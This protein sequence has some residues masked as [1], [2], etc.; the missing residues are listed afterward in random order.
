MESLS[1]LQMFAAL[2][3]RTCPRT[4]EDYFVNEVYDRMVASMNLVDC[5][6]DQWA[7]D[8]ACLLSLD[9]IEVEAQSSQGR[10]SRSEKRKQL[11]ASEYIQETLSRRLVNEPGIEPG[12]QGRC[13]FA[14]NVSFN[15]KQEMRMKL[16]YP[17]L[18]GR[19]DFS[20]DNM[21]NAFCK[22]SRIMFNLGWFRS[23]RNVLSFANLIDEV[24]THKYCLP[25]LNDDYSYELD[26]KSIGNVT[27]S[28]WIRDLKLF[29]KVFGGERYE[30]S[31][32]AKVC[33]CYN[34][35]LRTNSPV[36]AQMFAAKE[37][38]KDTV[39]ETARDVAPQI[40]DIFSA[41]ISKSVKDFVLQWPKY[42]GDA[43]SS[44]IESL[45]CPLVS[46]IAEYFSAIWIRIRSWIEKFWTTF[47]YKDSMLVDIICIIVIV[48]LAKMLLETVGIALSFLKLG[49][50]MFFR[51]VFGLKMRPSLKE[52][53]DDLF[54]AENKVEAQF[55]GSTVGLMSLA[56]IVVACLDYKSVSACGA[57]LNIASRA[58]PLSEGVISDFKAMIDSIY[59]Y[60][61]GDHLFTDI[62]SV[63]LFNQKIKDM[64]EF[65]S[66]PNLKEK[67][68]KEAGYTKKL[69]KL[70]E[71]SWNY[72]EVLK[73]SNSS[74]L[75]HYT[76]M[77][78]QLYEIH[79]EALA[80]A[81]MYKARIET[82]VIWL[83][84]K[85]KQGKTVLMDLLSQAVY[86]EL[87][88]HFGEEE[89]PSWSPAHVYERTKGSDY[90][91]GYWGQWGCKKNEILAIKDAAEK[92]KEILE[93]LNI[94][95]ESVFPLNMAFKEKGKAFFRSELFVAT[96]NFHLNNESVGKLG[97]DNPMALIR[98]RTFPMTI[99]RGDD[100]KSDY[101]NVDT[102]W[103]L[104]VKLP[105]MGEI[106]DH[107][108]DGLSEFLGLHKGMTNH[109]TFMKQGFF[110]FSFGQVVAAI[111][112]EIERRKSK[113][114]NSIEFSKHYVPKVF[115]KR[116][117]PDITCS[118]SDVSEA[119]M[120]E[121]IFD[122]MTGVPDVPENTRILDVDFALNKGSTN[123]KYF[124]LERIVKVN[125]D[126]YEENLYDPMV[127]IEQTLLQ[128]DYAELKKM[129]N[130]VRR[131]RHWYLRKL[132]LKNSD[133]P[134]LLSEFGN[135]KFSEIFFSDK[136]FT[137]SCMV[138]NMKSVREIADFPSVWRD[139]TF[140][141]LGKFFL[142]F[143]VWYKKL[144]TGMIFPER[145]DLEGLLTPDYVLEG[146]A[147]TPLMKIM[148][149]DLSL[150]EKMEVED[151]WNVCVTE[152]WKGASA[153][154][155]WFE[156]QS[157]S[158]YFLIGGLCVFSLGAILLP[159]F[160]TISPLEEKSTREYIESQM[161]SKELNVSS[162]SLERN[163]M[164]TKTQRKIVSAE[165]ITKS[166]L[167]KTPTMKVRADMGAQIQSR[168]DKA[169]RNLVAVRF[170]YSNKSPV[171]SYLF[172][173][174]GTVAVMTSHYFRAKGTDFT[175]MSI[176]DRI[177]GKPTNSF[178]RNS[179]NI[180][181]LDDKKSEFGS[182]DLAI[183]T[184]DSSQQHSFK[185]LRKNLPS[186]G[187]EC[188]IDGVVRLKVVVSSVATTQMVV[189]G[190]DFVTY[191]L[192]KRRD[193]ENVYNKTGGEFV[194]LVNYV[195]GHDMRGESGDCVLPYISTF[196]LD[197]NVFLEG[198]HVGSSGADAFFC[199]LYQEDLE[200]VF[201]FTQGQ[202]VLA[203]EAQMPISE[204]YPEE[205]CLS[206]NSSGAKHINGAR[207]FGSLE[208]SF[209]MPSKTVFVPTLFQGDI[210]QDPV[211]P[212][213]NAPAMLSPTYVDEILIEPLQKGKT[214]LGAVDKTNP[215][216]DWIL[217]WGQDNHNIFTDTFGPPSH[218]PRP[219]FEE[220]TIEEAV[221]GI[222][223]RQDSIDLT[224]SEG[225]SLKVLGMKRKDVINF[226][227]KFIHPIVR[228]KV[229]RLRA[230]ARKGILPRLV[231]IACMKD[232]LRDLPRV[233]LGKT[234]IFCIGDLIHMIW[235]RMVLGNLI[236][237]LKS[238][239]Y[240]TSGAIGTNTHGFDWSVLMS[241]LDGVDVE[242]GGG[243]YG[244]YDTGLRFWFGH[245][246]GLY[247]C[248]EM[249]LNY[250]TDGREVYLCCLSTTCPLLIIGRY[251]YDFDFMNP[252][253]GF[254]TGFL[255]TFVNVVLFHIFFYKLRSEC[256]GSGC[257]CGFSTETYNRII[258]AI[259]YG[260]DNIF[261]VLRRFGTHFN[262]QNISR[263]CLDM[264]GMEYT[265]ASKGV[266]ESPFIRRDEV[267]FLMRR[268]KQYGNFTVG[269]LDKNSIYSMILWIRD[270][271]SF[272][273]NRQ[274][275]QQNI[276]VAQMEMF[277]YGREEFE[278]FTDKIRLFARSRNVN[279]EFRPYSFYEERHACGYGY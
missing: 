250:K 77:Y 236:I 10:V 259:F 185:D 277:Y 224:T 258:R 268:F 33:E 55:M 150:Y 174:Y 255:N 59:F 68:M 91:E 6:Y 156:D 86:L 85:P 84:G 265:T 83:E 69:A 92:C 188:P 100:L 147:Y 19:R 20:I 237:W 227:T 5:S 136:I 139:Y 132:K 229:A 201:D 67:V 200:S 108:F 155:D 221:F 257:T 131:V 260:D 15:R 97:V 18:T 158:T 206:Y 93:I 21:R 8:A 222:P 169:T 95:E 167:E 61:K 181:F 214:K 148:F 149:K 262:M 134:N 64:E 102:S 144:K 24:I 71:E 154:W 72:R 13:D 45:D 4:I 118:M 38:M 145:D 235:T 96:T 23:S 180:R 78:Q 49:I 175:T 98:R 217:R 170:N 238:H 164:V 240:Q 101:S 48:F 197:D 186:F 242:Y 16:L 230:K 234:R 27:F 35:M 76:R 202:E 249:G 248:A 50:I 153:V 187:R 123:D 241:K 220:Q 261:S 173:I 125:S 179:I 162:Q 104:R 112:L 113:P 253:G 1:D 129:A 225:F 75:G 40:L 130:D 99:L 17:T 209:Y 103:R 203:V 177:G 146:R 161:L 246:M 226:D 46:Q 63:E 183:V 32:L 94:A 74:L 22:F 208:K 109:I 135:N 231:A 194:P 9:D 111:T 138:E 192:H 34:H 267:E 276:D 29:V 254:M 62:K 142:Y 210:N 51:K 269:P 89:Y 272:V 151:K 31:L 270:K 26:R 204:C 271:K 7:D 141:R 58:L 216:E 28:Y 166:K 119:Q 176:L 213:M 273:E 11:D 60:L 233:Y 168:F 244:G 82:V 275:L 121:E 196:H 30:T 274:Q 215:I 2:Q 52:A 120:W 264:F 163:K 37:Y 198:F 140:S 228:M 114:K 106:R 251:V 73:L 160:V 56:G 90:W 117:I 252:S 195:I 25:R 88:A 3:P 41:E 12:S 279:F 80:S 81:E 110:D 205:L 190:H 256:A 171:D 278:E 212:V 223:G 116:A 79:S 128:S 165:S 159:L 54:D 42:V 184:V 152:F 105:E 211:Y 127:L 245:L 189:T 191:S 70:I 115:R 218:V 219:R 232:E 39:V 247:C 107:F 53:V 157:V 143:L 43:I 182:R 36:Y 124:A 65:V 133:F 44:V 199:P 172:F 122:Y 239:R 178:G 207:Y 126:S 243:D 14:R 66:T 87:Q 137:C 57:V 47:G 263:L 266:V 193:V